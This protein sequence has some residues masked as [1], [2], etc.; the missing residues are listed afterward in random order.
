MD[1]PDEPA[2]WA[3]ALAVGEAAEV[4]RILRKLEKIV[5]A[6]CRIPLV[7]RYLGL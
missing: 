7:R 6:A 1:K 5:D 3:G 4:L 2:A